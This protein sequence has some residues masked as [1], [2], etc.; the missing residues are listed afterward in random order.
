MPD[1]ALPWTSGWSIVTFAASLAT[2]VT[3]ASFSSVGVSVCPLPPPP[4]WSR[5]HRGSPPLHSHIL[6]RSL[7]EPGAHCFSPPRWPSRMHSWFWSC[8]C[9][10][11]T[12]GQS[13][14]EFGSLCLCVQQHLSLAPRLFNTGKV[15]PRRLW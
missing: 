3:S 10:H 12:P 13:E 9:V 6:L 8:H 14:S 5:P 7:S 1:F 11:M 4:L 15:A 2:T